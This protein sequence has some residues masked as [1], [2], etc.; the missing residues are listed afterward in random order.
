MKQLI[1]KV[2]VMLFLVVLLG[3]LTV[4]LWYFG[5]RLNYSFAYKSLVQE[6][7]REMVRE[8]ALKAVKP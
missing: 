8:E 2:A 1:L 4:S 7:V 5:R 3:G 6:T